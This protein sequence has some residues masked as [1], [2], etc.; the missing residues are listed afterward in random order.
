MEEKTVNTEYIYKGRILNLRNDEV[1]LPDGRHA[2]REV[3]EHS[4]GAAVLAVDENDCVYLTEQFRYP[5]KKPLLE[6]P[7]GKLNSG[8]APEECALR[9]LR[10][11][12]GLIAKRLIPLGEL[13]PSPGYTEE[14]IYVFRAE[15]LICGTSSPDEDE[16]LNVIKMPLKKL[17]EKIKRNE[18]KDAKTVFGVL[19]YIFGK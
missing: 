8:E 4:G 15:G 7:A 5:Y 10:E 6:L 18:I 13:Y 1:L 2:F 12:T 17:L 9:E 11:E 3:I 19:R 16:F 14:I